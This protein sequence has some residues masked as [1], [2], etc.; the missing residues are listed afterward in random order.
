M[1]FLRPGCVS[2]FT[3]T[4]RVVEKKEKQKEALSADY[5]NKFEEK[6]KKKLENNNRI[7]LYFTL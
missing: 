2:V 3:K 1:S 6:E 5:D 7:F 4:K